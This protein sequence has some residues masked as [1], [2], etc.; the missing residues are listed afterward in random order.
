MRTGKIGKQFY[1]ER[2]KSQKIYKN[3]LTMLDKGHYTATLMKY[4]GA[5]ITDDEESTVP[6]EFLHSQGEINIIPL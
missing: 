4:N 6:V 1:C 3:A 5:L 2:L